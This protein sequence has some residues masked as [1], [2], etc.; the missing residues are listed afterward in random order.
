VYII[1]FKTE[2]FLLYQ[3][4]PV[5]EGLVEE[6]PGQL[7]SFT[8]ETSIAGSYAGKTHLVDALN[9]RYNNFGISTLFSKAAARNFKSASNHIYTILQKV[10]NFFF[11]N[12]VYML[13]VIAFM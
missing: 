6:L 9:Y 5:V 13:V 11:E 12:K 10:K 2:I 1:Y 8:F 3:A 4:D 7:A